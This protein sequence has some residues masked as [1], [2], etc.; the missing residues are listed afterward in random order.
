MS[1][2]FTESEVEAA[3]L[4]WLGSLGYTI[5]HGP[6]I[7]PGEPGAERLDYSQVILEDRLRQAL[8]CLNPDLPN[9]AI[10]D[11]FRKLTRPEGAS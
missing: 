3:A 7:A 9:E 6:E 4:A 8:Y 11:G 2:N 10:E 1:F 5:K